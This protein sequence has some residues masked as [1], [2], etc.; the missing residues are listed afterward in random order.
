MTFRLKYISVALLAILC[1]I[2]G[3]SWADVPTPRLKPDAPM[4]TTLVLDSDTKTFKSG[5]NAAKKR[6]WGSM[7]SYRKRLKDPVAQD[8]LIWIRAMKDA[9][10]S[11]EDLTYVVDNLSDWP[12]MVGIQAKAEGKMFN[13]PIGTSR[14]LSWFAT[15]DPISGEGRAALADAYYASGDTVSGDRWLK[16]AW[17]EAKLSRD[18]QKRIYGKHKKRLS[19]DDHAARA[20]YLIWEGT[21]HFS[22]IQGLLS[23]MA[24]DQRALMDARMRVLRNASGMDAAIKRVPSNLSNN[25][26]LLYS[27]AKWRRKKKTKE[28]ALPVYLQMI[29]PPVTEKGKERVWRE[30]KIMAYWA[31]EEKRY[32]DAYRLTRNHGM[33]RG[34]EFASAE[35]LG[36]WLALTKLGKADL[37]QQHFQTLRD[38][39]T[40]PVSLS[41]ASYWLG[42]AHEAAGSL[43]AQAHYADAARFP[44][45]YYGF[46]AADR[47]SPN[48]STINLPP[49]I[50]TPLAQSPLSQD[51]RIK[52]M[53]LLGQIGEEHYYTLFSFHLDD[54]LTSLDD[55]SLIAKLGAQFGYMRPSVRAAKQASRFQSMLT[56]TGY[57]VPAA[58]TNLPEKF[59]KA[60]V[61][62]IARQES[63]FNVSAVSSARAYGMMQMINSTASATARKHRVPYSKSRMTRDID[64][65][66]NLGALHLH[67]L[68]REF[69]GSYILAAAAYNAGSSRAKQW[70]RAYGDPRTGEI[71]PVDWIESVPFSETRNYIQRVLENLQIYRA[72]MNNNS[73]QN[74][75]LNDIKDGAF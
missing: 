4:L 51:N 40:F 11:M 54:V 47:L 62:A 60:F 8:V 56:E 69:D 35:F 57:P 53:T 12:R 71:D 59:D 50:T 9:N 16:L 14:T 17:R 32:S 28:Y 10:V 7:E 25:T 21:A 75:I 26:G 18:G 33:D 6:Q 5:V 24:P 72:R 15:R 1:L 70:M 23:V 37:A 3:Q 58:I 19:A 67:D 45:A 39:V 20:E 36:G 27:R 29:D 49:E 22:K 43:E 38:G 61:A 44:N 64:Y 48:Y 42:R 73:T 41:R 74:K 34:S 52:A 55:L 66:A 31:I 13:K 30:R 2:S 63:E 68:L 65:S 46:L